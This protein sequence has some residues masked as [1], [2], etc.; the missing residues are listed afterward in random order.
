[1]NQIKKILFIQ[2]VIIAFSCSSSSFYLFDIN[3]EELDNKSTRRSYSY[4]NPNEIELYFNREAI[5]R[6]YREIGVVSTSNYFYGEFFFDNVFMN[7]LRK[8]AATIGADA[9]IYE[10][11]FENFSNYSKEYIYFTAIEYEK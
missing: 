8:K 10:K 11:N 3:G 6:E 9:L 7:L 1:M 4:N 5:E 2:F